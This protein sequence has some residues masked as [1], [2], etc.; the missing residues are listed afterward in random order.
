MSVNERTIRRLV[1]LGDLPV[2][3]IV[4]AKWIAVK[5]WGQVIEGKK[6]WRKR[7]RAD[8]EIMKKF[9]EL[10]GIRKRPKKQL[11]TKLASAEFPLLPV[12]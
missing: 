10:L 1:N 3:K 11:T 12:P 4:R 7:T 8:S 5:D 2:V 6:D 9:N